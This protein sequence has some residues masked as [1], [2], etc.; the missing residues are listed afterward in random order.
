MF[1]LFGG[2]CGGDVDCNMKFEGPVGRFIEPT[3]A[4]NSNITA[5]TMMFD[6]DIT[7]LVADFQPGSNRIQFFY[8]VDGTLATEDW[9]YEEP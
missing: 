9:Y 7:G 3:D 8:F 4:Y 5:M 6:K 1:V 2:A